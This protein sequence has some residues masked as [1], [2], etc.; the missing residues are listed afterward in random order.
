MKHCGYNRNNKYTCLFDDEI[1]LIGEKIGLSGMNVETMYKEILKK[2]D[3]TGDDD[4]INRFR[5]NKDEIMKP[6]APDYYLSNT[7]I[8]LIMRQFEVVHKDFRSYGAVPYNFMD[9]PSGT[10]YD[11]TVEL[12]EL[13]LNKMKNKR[14]GCV[15]NLD[16]S[17]KGGSHWVCLYMMN[18]GKKVTVEYFDSI[19]TGECRSMVTCDRRNVPTSIKEYA[20]IIQKRSEDIGLKYKFKQNKQRHQRKYNECGMYCLYYIMNRLNGNEYT[21][22]IDEIEDDKMTYLRNVLFRPDHHCKKCNKPKRSS[23]ELI[24]KYK[25]KKMKIEKR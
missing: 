21:D 6:D 13:D 17:T 18:D 25:P 14:W 11:N 10:W 15:I 20:E 16:P 2:I 19:G 1:K 4:I 9:R 3:G 5:M 7:N 22:E 12:N 23:M 8:D 24:E